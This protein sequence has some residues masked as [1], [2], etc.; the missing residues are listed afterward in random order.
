MSGG[1]PLPLWAWS[2][3][4]RCPK[5][6]LL[7]VGEPIRNGGWGQYKPCQL[8]WGRGAGWLS[9]ES[10]G[11]G[12]STNQ[13]LPLSVPSH[14]HLLPPLAVF[15]NQALQPAQPVAAGELHGRG[16]GGIQLLGSRLPRC[17]LH[18]GRGPPGEDLHLLHRCPA[19]RS[20]RTAVRE[21]PPNITVLSLSPS[22]HL[23]SE[24]IARVV[25]KN[26]PDILGFHG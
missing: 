22:S 18:G 24:G 2:V 15:Q 19:A 8:H 5:E 11:E 17:R 25:F 4:N 23:Y 26:L 7:V 21:N 1:S 10:W 6:K 14:P 16:Y 3:G 13:M 20:P 12:L 9:D